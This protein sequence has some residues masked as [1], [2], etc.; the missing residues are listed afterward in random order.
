M[1]H[2]SQRRL[3]LTLALAY[4]LALELASLFPS[5][6]SLCVIPEAYYAG[7][8][9]SEGECPAFHFLIVR[10]FSVVYS[11][12]TDEKWLTAISTFV[13][14]IFTCVLGVFTVSLAKSTKDS[15]DAAI[16][17]ANA[18]DITARVAIALE[19]PILQCEP[20]PVDFFQAGVQGDRAIIR[21]VD[22]INKGKTGASLKLLSMGYAIGGSQPKP[23]YN[24]GSFIFGLCD[25]VEP[26][27]PRFVKPLDLSFPLGQGKRPLFLNEIAFGFTVIFSTRILSGNFA[28][29]P[30]VGSG[31]TAAQ[32]LGIPLRQ[33][34]NTNIMI[35]TRTTECAL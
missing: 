4:F 11:L 12:L 3:L 28:T 9:E 31:F 35:A 14:M 34:P 2:W 13:I 33:P 18:A 21:Y 25:T 23:K 5:Q 26:N 24:N 10:F 29:S 20:G 19:L 16:K 22:L 27:T 1:L 15:A 7:A 8:N 30:F 32:T 17:A 6:H